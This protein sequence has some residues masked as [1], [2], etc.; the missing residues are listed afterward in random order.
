MRTT[1][2]VSIF[3]SIAA[4]VL[5]ARE[6]VVSQM[7]A[8]WPSIA[9]LLTV[10]MISRVPVGSRLLSIVRVVGTGVVAGIA[11]WVSYWHMAGVAA[12]YGETGASAYLLPLSVDGIMI[13]GAITLAELTRVI[14]EQESFP[15]RSP[16]ESLSHNPPMSHEPTLSQDIYVVSRGEIPTEVPPPWAWAKEAVPDTLPDWR[17]LPLPPQDVVPPG[18]TPWAALL[19]DEEEREIEELWDNSDPE[20]P[21]VEVHLDRLESKPVPRRQGVSREDA[22]IIAGSLL[23]GESV[24]EIV[25]K[26]SYS[27][28]T[29]GRYNTALRRIRENPTA[30]VSQ[31]KIHPVAEQAFREQA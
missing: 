21:T 29:V 5:H 12:R 25:S 23:T 27:R 1:I 31:L 3:V 17:D 9:L 19:T 24:G 6:N 10:E 16:G 14:R 4:N 7:I 8:G 13:V 22:L 18:D 30:D 11:A 26:S 2:L 20:I 15:R 28:S